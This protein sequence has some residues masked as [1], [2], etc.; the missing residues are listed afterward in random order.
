MRRWRADRSIG[1]PR[2][3]D[4]TAHRIGEYRSRIGRRWE[5]I[6][7]VTT[8]LDE[9]QMVI[10]PRISIR[11]LMAIVLALAVILWLALPAVEVYRTKE[12]HVHQG[13]DMRGTPTLAAWGGIEPP[14]WPRYLKRLAGR[15]WRRQ[16]DC[17]FRTGYEDDRCEF[18]HPEM[19]V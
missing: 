3:G 16:P 11:Q 1:R 8:N 9:G 6:D 12:Y 5:R 4:N 18:A 2:E 7:A 19:V 10:R 15:P 17:G 14:F 13:I